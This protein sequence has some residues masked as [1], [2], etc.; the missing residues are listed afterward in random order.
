M[1]T[2]HYLCL[3]QWVILEVNI[4]NANKLIKLSKKLSTNQQLIEDL[5]LA[6]AI[7]KEILVG[8]YN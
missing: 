6:N 7:R 5:M 3:P 4:A 1:M 8:Y 2:I